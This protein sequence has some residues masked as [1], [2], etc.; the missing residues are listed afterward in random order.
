MG[1]PPEIEAIAVSAFKLR[2]LELIERVASGRVARLVLTKRG[3]PVAALV[4]VREQPVELWGALRE[5]MELVEGVDLTA[6][7]GEAWT[8]EDDEALLQDTCLPV[9]SSMSHSALS[10][11]PDLLTP[12]RLYRSTCGA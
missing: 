2:S 3:R 4:P 8:V 11:S 9:A 12:G 6:S 7:V 5:V 10:K 1:A